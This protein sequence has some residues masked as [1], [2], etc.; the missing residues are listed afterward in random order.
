MGDVESRTADPATKRM[1]RLAAEQGLETVWDRYEKMKPQCGY[2]QLGLCCRICLQGPCRINPFGG[3]PSRGV[4]GA[5]AYTIVSR[6]LI[7]MIAGGCAA[8]SD[9]GRHVAHTLLALVEGKA[10]A[11]KIKGEEKLRSV[12]ARLGLE[13]EGKSTLELAREVVHKALEDFSRYEHVP[14]TWTTTTMTKRRLE[15]LDRC[16]ILPYNIDAT[17]TEVLH[18]THI[19][20]DADPVPLIFTGLKCAIADLA[21]EHISTDLSDIL[22]GVPKLTK[23]RSNLGVIK[24]EMVNIAVHGHNPILSEV[25][26]DV[27]AEL[28]EEAKAAGAKGIN[29]IGICCT[30]NELL[31]RRGIPLATNFASQ[32]LAIMTGALDAM[33][34]DYQCIMPSLGF[35]ARCFHTQ[36]VSTSE[37]CRQ[38][39]DTHIEFHPET[40]EE[41]AKKI[42]R[43]AIEAFKRRDPGRINIP[44]EQSE[45]V[46]GFSVE[47]ILELLGKVNPDDP[48]QYLVDQIRD[49]RV[50]GIAAVVG[51]NNMKIVHDHGHL[52][53]AK[54]LVKNNVLI[55]ATGCAAGAYARAGLLTPAA[56]M[57]YAGEGLKMFLTE[58]GEKSGFNGPLPPVWH[59][60]SCVDNSRIHDLATLIAEKMGVDIKDLP[61][62]ASAPEAMS[63]KAVA[64]GS[65]LVVTGWPTHVG[66]VPFIYG[67]RLV[68]Q[69][70]ENTAR[71]VYGGYFI[72]EKDPGKAAKRL[73]NVIRHRRWRLGI[74][75]DEYI[76]YWPGYT[77]KEV[78]AEEKA[79]KT[80][81][82]G[83][84]V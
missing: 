78:F 82:N 69:I 33:V 65:W 2:G 40:A 11:Y 76:T 84:D 14:L 60:G 42:I 18:R 49:G 15:L 83:G 57:E 77:A 67:S 24:P 79:V 41:D 32:E 56:T 45:A 4:C 48:V 55:V 35:W 43:L 19:G 1:L 71:D 80:M 70:A 73:L 46:V 10:P 9:H 29:I 17:I 5:T 37:L 38:P 47:Q 62:A 12:A 34:V 72:F 3:E 50:L 52:T 22:F 21:G 58:L 6:N 36:L 51:C 66:V 44:S 13:V 68:T 16:D 20:V 54:E 81:A 64:I 23:T 39:G 75:R 61:V 8:H 59:M 74:S 30:G 25:I 31:M 26:C 27:A 63:E 53:I 28:E 7:R